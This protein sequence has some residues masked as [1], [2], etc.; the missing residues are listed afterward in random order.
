MMNGLS[1]DILRSLYRH[2]DEQAVYDYC[3]AHG[4]NGGTVFALLADD[5]PLAFARNRD[6]PIPVSDQPVS[7]IRPRVKEGKT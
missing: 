4:L 5:E 1:W 6:T 2:G 7:I 3:E